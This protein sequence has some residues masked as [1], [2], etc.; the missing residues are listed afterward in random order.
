LAFL[1]SNDG[2]GLGKEA[3]LT[4]GSTTSATQSEKETLPLASRVTGP[5]AGFGPRRNATRALGDGPR[6]RGSG[7]ELEQA[8]GEGWARN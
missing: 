4:D 8:A 2:V 3:R 7:G 6:G 5:A 1:E